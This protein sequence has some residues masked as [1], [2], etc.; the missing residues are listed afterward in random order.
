MALKTETVKSKTI[1]VYEL[2][3]YEKLI[4]GVKVAS[5]M[6]TESHQVGKFLIYII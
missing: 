4:K 5:C 2:D 3:D 6:L 1:K